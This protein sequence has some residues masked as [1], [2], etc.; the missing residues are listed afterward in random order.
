MQKAEGRMGEGKAAGCLTFA[1]FV[2]FCSNF[3]C[4]LLFRFILRPSVNPLVTSDKMHWQR[5][6][7]PDV[8]QLTKIAA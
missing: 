6:F 1:N 4:F 2:T 3:L 8:E 7:R 5:A